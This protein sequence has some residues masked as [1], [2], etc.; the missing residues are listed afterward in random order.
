MGEGQVLLK[1]ADR[2]V[3]VHLDGHTNPAGYQQGAQV[4]GR[5]VG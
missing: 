4:L 1:V 5:V 3:R 2:R